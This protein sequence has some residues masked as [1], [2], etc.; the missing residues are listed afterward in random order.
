MN[1][2]L[3]APRTDHPVNA[4]GFLQQY[5]TVREHLAGDVAARDLAA[6]WLQR[7]GLPR[8]TAE[9][10]KYT[11]LRRLWETRFE[12]MPADAARASATLDAVLADAGLDTADGA[13][14]PRLVFVNGRLSDALTRLPQGLAC[15]AFE[16]MSAAEPIRH[17]MIALNTMLAHGGISL[18]VPAGV[19]AGRLL[20]VTL[21]I[22]D[23]AAAHLRHRFVLEDGASLSLLEIAAGEGGYL[24]DSMA[25][26]EVGMGAHARHVRLQ[27][28]AAGALSF[29]TVRAL[30]A[31]R[32]AY[33]G[34]NLALG[35]GLARHEVHATLAGPHGAVHV[36]GAQ[37]LADSQVADL[38]SVIA[39]DAPNCISRQTVKNVLTARSRGV[40]Q[41]K[42]IVARPAQKTDGYQMNQALLLSA[43]AEIDCKPELE[44]Y[45]DDVKCSH[46]ATA[47]AL[48]EEQM[49]YMRSRGIPAV[50][51]RAILVRAF[52]DDALGLV[53]DELARSML[54]RA[55][56]NWW[57]GQAT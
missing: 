28:E 41:G 53:E 30:V 51:A 5:Q 39:H 3:A 52:L 36:N 37:L 38:T 44:I 14:L 57:I 45:A 42:I 25:E 43:E 23:A 2:I 46:G 29:S 4:D 13:T 24:N 27:R 21:G 54:D 31:E 32:G 10:W 19:D 7:H 33:D 8:R 40:F 9:A 17:P 6:A 26:F 1:V 35:A 34:F 47:G 55:V 56:A 49:F 18:R 15:T 11:D 48:D 16:G 22:G 50:E 12:T 20:L